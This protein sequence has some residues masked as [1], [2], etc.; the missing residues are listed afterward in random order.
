SVFLPVIIMF[1]ATM[2]FY[3]V[4]L[5]ILQATGANIDWQVLFHTTLIPASVVNTICTPMVYWFV[6]WL[7]DRFKPG[8]NADW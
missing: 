8:R 2:V 4:F 3:G 5:L 1:G 6:Q 7:S